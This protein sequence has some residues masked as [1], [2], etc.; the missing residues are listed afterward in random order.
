VAKGSG[1][2][3]LRSNTETKRDNE[4]LIP[5]R[6]I[7]ADS[8]AIY[9][10]GIAKILS[11]EPDLRVVAQAETLGQAFA[12]LTQS[13]ADVMLFE[14]ALSPTPVEAVVEVLKRAPNLLMVV[15][16]DSPR[17]QETVDYLR[18]GVRGVVLRSIAPELLVRCVRK[19]FQGETWIDTR[20]IN[21][22]IKAFRNQSAQLRSADPRHRLSEKELLIIAGV[23]QGL[24]NKDIA[25][26]IG[27]TEQ[28]VKNYLRKIYDKLRINDRLEL[29]LYTV[30][31][32]LLES[33]RKPEAAMEATVGA[34]AQEPN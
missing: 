25:V 34:P 32:K 2:S 8:Q 28:V 31:E 18:R 11:A 14:A 27:T 33:G 19:V 30:H 16:V 6:V 4:V 12:A 10:V 22:V 20:G 5:I 29:A 21:W 17:E 26:E 1:K 13:T 9:R 23:T 3:S 24:R 7:L 15:L